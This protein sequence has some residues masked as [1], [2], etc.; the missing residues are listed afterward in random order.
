MALRLAYYGDDFTGSTDVMEVLQRVGV[1]TV[2][3]LSPPKPEELAQF[4]G[5]EAFGIAGTAR[6]MSVSEMQSELSPIFTALRETGAPVVHY[7][8]CSTFDSSPEIGNIGC[9][10][11]LG[12]KIFGTR[13]VPVVVAAPHLS[14]YQVFGNLFA[15]SGRN[16]EP[17]R[18]D[19]HPTMSQHPVTP[20][21]ES[22]LRLVLSS[23]NPSTIRLIDVLKIDCCSA[24]ELASQVVSMPEDVVLFDAL[25]REQLA[26]IGHVMDDLVRQKACRFIV[27]SS[28]VE[29]ALTA[30]WTSSKQDPPTSGE[31]VAQQP[32]QYSS[33]ERLLVMT[34]SCSPVNGRQIA[35]AER[36][37]FVSLEIDTPALV[38]DTT[39]KLEMERVVE[40]AVKAIDH[41][42]NLIVHSSR[43]P[44]DPRVHA[45]N[46]RLKQLGYSD[47]EVKLHGGRILGPKLGRILNE[48]LTARPFPRV[49]IAG[50]DSS[51]YLVK[52]LG[53]W[54]LEAA[55]FGEPG[56]PVCRAHA[57]HS[58]SGLELILKGGQVGA[59]DIWPGM[60]H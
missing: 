30:A 16:S 55:E 25:T 46:V 24:S 17:Y 49:G 37:G 42:A 14:R 15:T 56:A 5:L 47:W 40:Q 52:Q 12:S 19:R 38:D 48:I 53:V 33:V 50:G 20:M 43:G 57:T 51:S 36:A 39:A 2:L 59:D 58:K 35:C 10:I 13:P 23:Q 7:K 26:K 27:G 31:N 8:T 34:G 54:A 1:R 28:G 32:C 21:H 18:L 22:D 6:A 60:V 45:T 44:E 41:G 9:V 3:F 29:G 11:E 4:P